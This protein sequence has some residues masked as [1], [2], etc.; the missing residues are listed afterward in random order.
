MA[1]KSFWGSFLRRFGARLVALAGVFGRRPLSSRTPE[2]ATRFARQSSH[3]N[4]SRAKVGL[5]EPEYFEGRLETST[6]IID[7]LADSGIW[8]LSTALERNLGHPVKAR[9]DI[10]VTD[11]L[12]TGLLTEVDVK[13]ERHLLIVGW[14]PT[15]PERQRLLL[16]LA[17]APSARLVRRDPPTTR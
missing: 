10:L 6:F 16:L 11:V 13:V 15:K 14:P 7:G 1:R 2:L 5:F 3:Y 8:P 9:C 4:A 17:E 12:S